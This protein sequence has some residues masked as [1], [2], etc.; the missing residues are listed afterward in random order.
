MRSQEDI[1]L[2]RRMNA[3]MLELF[4]LTGQS[5]VVAS[6]ENSLLDWLYGDKPNPP[7]FDKVDW[8]EETVAKA[9]AKS[10]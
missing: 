5:T 10:A 3:A 1:D 2:Y 6:V 4:E 7:Y 9:R 8:L